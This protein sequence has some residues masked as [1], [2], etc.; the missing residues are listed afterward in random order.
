MGDTGNPTGVVNVRTIDIADV[1]NGI[2]WPTTVHT[3]MVADDDVI[4]DNGDPTSA[5]LPTVT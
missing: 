2:F 1:A 3:G 5:I 4:I